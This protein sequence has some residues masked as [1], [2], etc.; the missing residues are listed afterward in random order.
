MPAEPCGAAVVRDV[1]LVAH[2]DH[3]V[4]IGIAD[5]HA[6]RGLAALEAFPARGGFPIR[7][8]VVALETRILKVSGAPGVAAVVAAIDRVAVRRVETGA[9][10]EGIH[11]E[12]FSVGRQQLVVLRNGAESPLVGF[13]CLGVEAPAH[14]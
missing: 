12:R 14:R 7:R 2:E 11:G 10:V 5:R 13:L 3:P 1:R 4:G 8:D 9:G 6:E